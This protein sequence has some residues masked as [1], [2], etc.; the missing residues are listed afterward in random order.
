MDSQVT[1]EQQLASA[2]RVYIA[3]PAGGKGEDDRSSPGQKNH[4]T[5]AH[6]EDDSVEQNPDDRRTHGNVTQEKWL[7]P[8]RI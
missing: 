6:G 3:K 4:G 5:A 2:L 7:W 1:E 8:E